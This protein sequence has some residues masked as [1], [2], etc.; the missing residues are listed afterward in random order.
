MMKPIQLIF[1]CI[2]LLVVLV[3]CAPDSK[4]PKKYYYGKLTAQVEE[5]VSPKDFWNIK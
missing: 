4:D 3:M 1:G 5:R 2:C